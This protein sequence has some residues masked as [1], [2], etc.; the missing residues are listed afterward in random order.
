MMRIPS[1]MGLFQLVRK[2][3]PTSQFDDGFGTPV[4]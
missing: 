4:V 1:V 3:N 2:D